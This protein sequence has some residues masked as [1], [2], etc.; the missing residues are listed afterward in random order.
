MPRGYRRYIRYSRNKKRYS[1]ETTSI[2]FESNMTNST[3]PVSGNNPQI[4]GFTLVGSTT[5]QGTRKVKNMTISLSSIGPP[6]PLLCA[7]VYCPG[8]MQ[9][10]ELHI[11][12]NPNSGTDLYEPSQNVI[13]QFVL[14]PSITATLVNTNVQTFRTRLA[15]N[16]DSND[17]IA[18]IVKPAFDIANAAPVKVSGVFNYAIAY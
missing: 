3:Y 15:R 14:N 9:P 16:L 17:Y 2:A 18:L 8:G 12:T 10:Q 1:N 4:R 7:V 6:V 5:I 11:A 13:M